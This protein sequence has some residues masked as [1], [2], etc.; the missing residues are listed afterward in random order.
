MAVAPRQPRDA[1]QPLARHGE[2]H[3][4]GQE[5]QA[6]QFDF[7]AEWGEIAHHAFQRRLARV[8]RDQSA[9]ID[10]IPEQPTPVGHDLP[11]CFNAWVTLSGG[12]WLRGTRAVVNGGEGIGVARMLRSAI[13]ASTRVFDAL[14]LSRR[15]HA[16][17]GLQG[18]DKY[19][20]N[21]MNAKLQT[22][23]LDRSG[24]PGFRG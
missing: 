15:G 17:T 7:R 24:A 4:V 20:T 10:T 21:A 8:E 1:G 13:S 14:R 11:R 23:L 18:V 22:C 16:A 19:A 2:I 9:V 3:L 5:R 6:F 12:K